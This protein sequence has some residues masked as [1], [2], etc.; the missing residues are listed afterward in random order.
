MIKDFFILFLYSIISDV[1]MTDFIFYRWCHVSVKHGFAIWKTEDVIVVYIDILE[2]LSM[3][4][5]EPK[6]CTYNRGFN[7]SN[8]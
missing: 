1:N 5:R 2:S 3:Y 4:H 8:I 6:Q 7:G